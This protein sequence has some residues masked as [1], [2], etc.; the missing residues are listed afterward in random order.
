MSGR[1]FCAVKTTFRR[2][3]G[4]GGSPNV[5]QSGALKFVLVDVII[6]WERSDGCGR[7]NPISRVL[8]PTR[9]FGK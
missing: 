6:E 4:I 1:P 8:A 9:D 2:R 3:L 5:A 7:T